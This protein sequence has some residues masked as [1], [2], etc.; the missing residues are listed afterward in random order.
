M[1][2][3]GSRAQC[4]EMERFSVAGGCLGGADQPLAQGVLRCLV[5]LAQVQL[6]Q[7]VAHVALDGVDA[8]D[9]GLRD[10]LIGGA[11]RH[12]AQHLLLPACQ[13]GDLFLRHLPR[14]VAQ[15]AELLEHAPAQCGRDG[16][17]ASHRPAQHRQKLL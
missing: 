7:D 11:L 16:C 9:Q 13:G 15:A 17:L 8:D 12:L 1:A 5:A 2:P 14:L 3:A 10:L 6:G 4:P